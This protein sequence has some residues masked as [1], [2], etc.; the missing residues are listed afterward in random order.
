[1]VFWNRLKLSSHNPEVRRKAMEALDATDARAQELLLAGLD[2]E[3][4]GVRCAAAK[5]LS[6]NKDG[7]YADA[8]IAALHDPSPEVREAVAGGLA[9]V[10]NERAHRPLARLLTDSHPGVRSAAAGALR[11]LGWRAATTD[12]QVLFDVALGHARAAAFAGQAAVKALVGELKH[13]TSFTRRAAAEALE[14]VGD[15]G[16]RQPLLAALADKDPSVRV[17]AIHALGKDHSGEV[18][19]R[20]LALL[21]DA[22][23]CVRLATA[24][25]LAKRMDPALARDFVGLLGDGSFEVRLTAVKFLGRIQDPAL[26]VAL[27]PLLTDLDSDVRQAV[28][29]ALGTM[30]EPVAIE[31]LVLALTDEE[32]AV[33]QAAGLA[34]GQIDGNWAHSEAA[35]RASSRIEA[36][37]NDQHAW[38][39]SAAAQVVAKLHPAAAAEPAVG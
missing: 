23:P 14:E 25:V 38:V 24:E 37:L 2:D 10:G 39:R 3:D 21:R 32:R 8:L 35:Q 36:K 31:A 22:D 15:P 5:V 34:L 16:A 30:G 1:M 7:H 6:Q 20:L 26:A 28:A 29:V 13:D 33:R 12:E 4:G 9:R 11:R 27:L 19:G 18:V 17:S